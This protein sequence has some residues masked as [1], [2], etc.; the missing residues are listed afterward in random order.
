MQQ[1][2]PFSSPQTI[3]KARKKIEKENFQLE[4]I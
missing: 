2:K 4:N 1:N 3:Q